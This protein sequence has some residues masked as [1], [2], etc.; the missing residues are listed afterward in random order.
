[1]GSDAWPPLVAEILASSRERLRR[2]RPR[3]GGFRRSPGR[4]STC[5]QWLVIRQPA[6]DDGPRAE[7]LTRGGRRQLRGVPR[8]LPTGGPDRPMIDPAVDA[9]ARVAGDHDARSA[10]SGRRRPGVGRGLE[11][12]D[13]GAVLAAGRP[14]AL[15]RLRDHRTRRLGR[16]RH[17]L[18]TRRNRIPTARLV[19]GD[20]LAEGSG[21]VVLGALVGR[22]GEDRAGVVHLDELPGLP[23]RRQVEERRPVGDPRGLL[24]VVRDDDDRVV[25]LQLGGSGPR[26][27]S[28]RSGP[29][30][31]RARPS[32]ARRAGPRSRARCTAAAVGRRTARPRA[33][34]AGP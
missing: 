2:L 31:S 19:A 18:S 14:V 22:V 24:H 15:A 26:S 7:R 17:A 30:P 11:R 4:L 28:S 29:A 9:G 25:L 27:P 3:R 12:C 10:R 13:C 21:D 5:V 8:P 20:R 32:A 16:A 33:C 34:S 1:M 6:P 23:D